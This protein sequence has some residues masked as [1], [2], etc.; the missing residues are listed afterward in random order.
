[1]QQGNLFA[2]DAARGTLLGLIAAAA[3]CVA[4]AH[5]SV[6]LRWAI[7]LPIGWLAFAAVSLLVYR[8]TIGPLACL[9][10]AVAALL[11]ARWLLPSP[12]LVASPAAAPRWDLPL[13]MLSAAVLVYL[14]TS[15]AD[16][17]GSSVSGVLT[18]FPVATAIISGFTHAQRGSAAAVAF[19]RGFLPGLC[20]F[21]VFCFVLAVT[22]PSWSLVS[23]VAVALAT[24]LAIQALLLA[25]RV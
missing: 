13:R 14:L 21:A 24:Q 18:P 23:S 6:R 9:T 11:L 22:L 15:L 10:M 20:T 1:V 25:R 5:G 8:A 12:R 19:L 16:R 7:C 2:A 17:L 3:F 4:Y